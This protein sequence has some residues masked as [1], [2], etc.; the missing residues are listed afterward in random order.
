MLSF[1]HDGMMFKMHLHGG[2]M[3]FEMHLC[4]YKKES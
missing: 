2:I 4:L 1:P 3:L